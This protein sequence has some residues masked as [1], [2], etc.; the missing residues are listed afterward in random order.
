[1][2][3]PVFPAC[4]GAFPES[5][6]VGRALPRP[7]RT[8]SAHRRP[9][10]CHCL[11]IS[12]AVVSGRGVSCVYHSACGVS[13]QCQDRCGRAP[14]RRAASSVCSTRH[15]G[16]N[17]PGRDGFYVQRRGP[18]T[19]PGSRRAPLV[20]G[21]DRFSREAGKSSAKGVGHRTVLASLAR[22]QPVP[23]PWRAPLV[24]GAGNLVGVRS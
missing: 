5:C 15:A 17:Q 24:R 14:Q 19:L 21:A 13:L 2:C 18:N 10:G 23:I 11:S 7:S 9:G 16:P 22:T 20:R 4:V 1:V 12:Q 8:R 6:F 3:A